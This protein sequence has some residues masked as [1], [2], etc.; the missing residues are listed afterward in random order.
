MSANLDIYPLE[1]LPPRGEDLPYDDGEPME[2]WRHKCQMDLLIGSLE[3]AWSQRFDFFVSGNMF[4]YFS[5]TQAK[6][7]DYR[8]P[9]VFV[10]LGTE[11]KERKSW[12]VWEED[13]KTPQVVIELTSPTTERV[14][15]GV[16]KDLYQSLRVLN[17]FIFDPFSKRLDGFSLSPEAAGAYVP[18]SPLPNGD[19]PCPA[20][21]LSV[22]IRPG[23]FRSIETEWLRWIGSDGAVFQSGDEAAVAEMQRAAEATQRADEATQRADEATQRAD[24]AAREAEALARKLAEYERRFGPLPDPPER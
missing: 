2:T 22:G 17:Y 4:F 1:K 9:D 8:G 20:L 24:E 15:R 19:L 11:R 10:V 7:N 21:G 16:K 5:E 23:R 14:D 18:I 6:R 13:G 3:F 12:V